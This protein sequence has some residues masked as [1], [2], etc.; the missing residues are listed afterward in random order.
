M[1]YFSDLPSTRENNFGLIRLC[2][3]LAVI[4]SHSFEICWGTR[5]PFHALLNYHSLGHVAVFVFF[6]ISGYL[7][8]QSYVRRDDPVRF[9]LARILRI[10]PALIVMLLL[11]LLGLYL[12]AKELDFWSY[13]P[14]YL[15]QNIKLLPAQVM[16][17][18]LF[19]DHLRPF[20]LNLPLWTLEHELKAYLFVLILGVCGL[21]RPM[22]VIASFAIIA[23]LY[24]GFTGLVNTQVLKLFF[25][26]TFGAG[27]YL[28]RKSIPY[29]GGI[30]I[31]LLGLCAVL[32]VTPLFVFAMLATL[33]YGAIW[34]GHKKPLIPFRAD[35]SYGLY[36]YAYGLQ[37]IAWAWGAQTVGGNFIVSVVLTLPFAIASWHLIEAPALKLGRTK[38]KI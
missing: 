20:A 23:I 30:V 25:C 19:A 22:A 21:L 11:T 27:L 35:Y 4:L 37:Q 2:A 14:T 34:A 9:A 31:A 26:F 29:H 1:V 5:D 38:P 13:G 24:V 33:S 8:T 6:A 28:W 17:P 32:Y 36:I 3:A 18:G 12:F 7:I 10:Y 16:M 15:W